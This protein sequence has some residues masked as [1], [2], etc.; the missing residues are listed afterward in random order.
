MPFRCRLVWC[1]ELFFG[2]VRKVETKEKAG[3]RAF[4]TKVGGVVIFEGKDW[5]WWRVLWWRSH[6]VRC[7][8]AGGAKDKVFNSIPS[9]VVG[10]WR[11]G[12]D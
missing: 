11:F 1:K 6:I 10:W 7:E 3:P 9:G 12:S 8:F 2:F 5:R 4:D